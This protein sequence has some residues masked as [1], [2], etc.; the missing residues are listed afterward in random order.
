MREAALKSTI[1]VG[2]PR[3]CGV[4]LSFSSL[5]QQFFF[6]FHV[7]TIGALAGLTG[8]LEKDVKAGLRTDS[9]RCGVCSPTSLKFGVLLKGA[10]VCGGATSRNAAVSSSRDATPENINA[11]TANGMALWNSIYEPHAVKLY[12]KLGSYYPDFM[13]TSLSPFS[14]RLIFFFSSSFLLFFSALPLLGDGCGKCTASH[15]RTN[16]LCLHIRITSLPSIVIFHHRVALLCEP[17]GF[18]WQLTD[19]SVFQRSLS[20]RTAPCCHRSREGRMNKATSAAHWDPSWASPASAPRAALGHSLRATFSVC[21][22]RARPM[23]SAK[24]T[25]GSR[26]TRAPSGSFE[27]LIRSWMWSSLS[28]TIRKKLPNWRGGRGEGGGDLA[29]PPSR[30]TILFFLNLYLESAFRRK[31]M[32]EA[33]RPAFTARAEHASP[34]RPCQGPSRKLARVDV[35]RWNMMVVRTLH[36][37]VKH[38]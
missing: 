5:P 20:S 37:R 19:R 31:C 21:S 28:G 16:A 22:R 26:A 35:S 17:Y 33:R 6:F 38:E 7:Q 36:M 8:A 10:R 18:G 4:H 29:S 9:R 15:A 2:V 11:I 1:F 32:W 24:K 14:V 27:P 12:E 3:V 25:A 34:G 13:C 30:Q 23:A